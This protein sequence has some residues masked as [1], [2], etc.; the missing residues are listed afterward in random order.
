[1]QVLV[2]PQVDAGDV[3]V[4]RVERLVSEMERCGD[5]KAMCGAFILWIVEDFR[6][7]ALDARRVYARGQYSGPLV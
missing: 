4:P 1:M 6:A 3:H 5:R 2:G 7:Q